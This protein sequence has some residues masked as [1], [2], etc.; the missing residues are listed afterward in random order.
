MKH[1]VKYL[2]KNIYVEDILQNISLYH[3]EHILYY[4]Y[5]LQS[6]LIC[7]I[8]HISEFLILMR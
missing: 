7:F 3:E 1:T 6:Q 5:R 4:T 2:Q 8:A